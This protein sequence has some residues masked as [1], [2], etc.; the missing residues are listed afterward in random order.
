MV[1]FCI[2]SN[3]VAKIFLRGE[4]WPTVS[5]EVGSDH[6]YVNVAYS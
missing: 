2:L 3:N 1:I 4:N 5:E 6:V